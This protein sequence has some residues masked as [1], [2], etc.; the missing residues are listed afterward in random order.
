VVVGELCKDVGKNLMGDRAAWP[1]GLRS[2]T[3]FR[4]RDK[5]LD[6]GVI[7]GVEQPSML[8]MDGVEAGEIPRE[9]LGLNLGGPDCNPELD[10]SSVGGEDTA[11]CPSKAPLACK[12]AERGHMAVVLGSSRLTEA[13]PQE[14]GN[15]WVQMRVGREPL[16]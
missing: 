5:S 14:L 8:G 11:I 3:T 9:G 15:G 16:R 13:V 7:E 10:S 12:L 4:R 2:I 6:N 1:V